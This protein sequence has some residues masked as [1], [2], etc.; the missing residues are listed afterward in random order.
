MKL[1]RSTLMYG[2][3]SVKDSVDKKDVIPSLQ[4]VLIKDGTMTTYNRMVGSFVKNLKLE[5]FTVLIPFLKL[6]NFVKSVSQETID[7]DIEDEVVTIKAGR[8]KVTMAT[9][10]TADF[11]SFDKIRAAAKK[12]GWKP[13]ADLLSALIQCAPFASRNHNELM[14]VKLDGKEVFA[15]DSR[16]IA[17]RTLSSAG[18]E[19]SCIFTTDFILNLR[20]M[21]KIESVYIDDDKVVCIGDDLTIFGSLLQV[22]FPDVLKFFPKPSK[23][24]EF[25]IKDLIK[26]LKR[27]C[28]FSEEANDRKVATIQFGKSLKIS[29]EGSTAEIREYFNFGEVL[30]D[31]PFLVN[32]F[33]FMAMLE[34]CQRFSFL[35]GK[36]SLLY[37]QSVKGEFK[38]VLA[39][40]EG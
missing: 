32:P 27:V 13:P 38:V 7:F 16:R 34:G 37:G 5:K 26:G 30:Y 6:Y 33:H 2:L 22:D 3:E 25:P 10:P 31:K 8:A 29:Y 40:K 14:G 24:A 35:A 15:T 36:L 28:D 12:E 4:G 20:K 19:G 17:R 23:L 18:V 9:M 21:E 11:P 1:D 39:I